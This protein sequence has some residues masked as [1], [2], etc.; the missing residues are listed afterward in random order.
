MINEIESSPKSTELYK[1]FQRIFR[2]KNLDK[3]DSFSNEVFFLSED[4]EF[5]QSQK[6]KTPNPEN[7][8]SMHRLLRSLNKKKDSQKLLINVHDFIK[9]LSYELLKLQ[10]EKEKLLEK[11]KTFN[12]DETINIIEQKIYNLENNQSLFGMNYKNESCIRISVSRIDNFPPGDYSFKLHLRKIKKN[13][14]I[15]SGI[16]DSEDINY[17]LISTVKK[18][19]LGL[20]DLKDKIKD[21]TFPTQTVS[22]VELN[23]SEFKGDD[24]VIKRFSGTNIAYFRLEIT[25]TDGNIYHSNTQDLIDLNIKLVNFYTDFTQIKKDFDLKLICEKS[26]PKDDL[27]SYCLL[28]SVS[29][30][31]DALVR[32]SVLSRIY[33]IFKNT[34]SYRT[35][36]DSN[37]SEFLKYFLSFSDDIKDILEKGHNEERSRCGDCACL[38]I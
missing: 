4:I 6:A 21:Y 5:I 33:Y 3:D 35:L 9:S 12:I 31:I 19:T 17:N 7:L 32:K 36:I 16:I 34:I 10:I 29:L 2:A 37:Q 30:E 1:L 24:P 14:M 8:N 18:E 27:N 11:I 23:Y 22:P 15:D 28:V 25:D 20:I 38:I 13:N 26:Y